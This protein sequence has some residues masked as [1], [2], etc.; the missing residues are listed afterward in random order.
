MRCDA[1]MAENNDGV[2][3]MVCAG[4]SQSAQ[5]DDCERQEQEGRNA[6]KIWLSVWHHLAC[7]GRGGGKAGKWVRIIFFCCCCSS[8]F[9]KDIT[10]EEGEEK[11]CVSRKT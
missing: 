9:C 11:W 4:G 2:S 1:A 6:H 7:S 3:R 10:D 5:W 8:R